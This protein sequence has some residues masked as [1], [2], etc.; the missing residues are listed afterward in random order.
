MFLLH[1]HTSK[2]IK[3]NAEQVKKSSSCSTYYSKVVVARSSLFFFFFFSWFCSLCGTR[4]NC[5][6]PE[7][8]AIAADAEL[9]L[10]HLNGDA[11]VNF[12]R[13]CTQSNEKK[14]EKGMKQN[15]A[16]SM[17]ITLSRYKQIHIHSTR[18]RMGSV[19]RRRWCTENVWTVDVTFVCAR[20]SSIYPIVYHNNGKNLPFLHST[21]EM[22]QSHQ[23]FMHFR[24]ISF[25]CRWFPPFP[26]DLTHQIVRNTFTFA[27]ICWPTHSP[28]AVLHMYIRNSQNNYQY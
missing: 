16:S 25:I 6:M 23:H 22:V 28:V 15:G 11:S 17:E 9:M 26:F 18:L 1:P 14:A 20:L 8:I 21:N 12:S 2:I 7:D 10:Q 13:E 19:G 5:K 27:T 24:K 4:R 3:Y